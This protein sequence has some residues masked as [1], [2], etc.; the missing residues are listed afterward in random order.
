M[1]MSKESI[2]NRNLGE[3]FTPDNIS[4][5]LFETTNK[6]VPNFNKT[7][8]VW[9]CCWG[10]GNLTKQFE[11]E[12]LYCSTIRAVDIRNNREKNKNAVKFVYNFL[13]TDIDQLV[14]KQ[15]MWMMEHEL[16]EDLVN[17]LNGDK[18]LM[19]Y[20]NPPYAATGVLGTTGDSREDQTISRMKEVMS[21][22]RMGTACDQL[23][24]Q[25][26]YRIGLM[27]DAYRN[28]N[29]SIACIAPPMFLSGN[30]YEKFRDKLLKRFKFNG[31][32]LVRA[33]NFE[34]LS[35]SWSI[36]IMV[37]TSGET[38]DKKNFNFDV[39]DDING[40][41]HKV[42]TKKIYNLSGEDTASNWVKRNTYGLNQID[43]EALSSGCKVSNK[44]G[45]SLP[46]GAYGYFF[47]RS[48]NVYHNALEVGIL[49][50]AYSGN[51][52]SPIIEDNFDECIALFTA[53]KSIGRYSGDWAGDKDEYAIPNTD[54]EAYKILVYNGYIYSLFNTS[55]GMASLILDID[56]RHI[57][58][59]NNFFP[60]D[61]EY[62]KGLFD[63]EGLKV[64]GPG[65]QENRVMVHKLNS[66]LNTR[67]I[68]QESLDVLN[69]AIKIYEDTMK[70][71]TEFNEKNPEYQ[72]LNWDAG[73]YQ[74]R[75]IL[76]EV[77]IDKFRQ[78]T[79]MYKKLENKLRPLVYDCGFLR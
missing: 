13:D 45:L 8:T 56:N 19:F 74:I 61:I 53:R 70:Y 63:K 66:A 76:K 40:E 50:S 35:S 24:A 22:H 78:F 32:C 29:I 51:T 39:Y 43:V 18:P 14:S 44:N 5:L 20:I 9:D 30:G 16:R 7:H 58:I 6:Y 52:G 1:E 11:F 12:D 34:G 37:L 49:S 73:Y 64:V 38:E 69:E 65:K 68:T 3:I 77:D 54:C 26:L 15:A 55:S 57:E 23:Y 31:G 67:Y 25:F 10:T 60:I 36:A 17:K 2:R 79:K 62:M 59:S 21:E 27:Q 72:V 4:K 33:S 42:R 28:K 71:R 75:Q 41:L 48:N 47:Y 46:E